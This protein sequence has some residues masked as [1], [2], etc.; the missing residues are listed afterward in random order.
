[1]AAGCW[2]TTH[3]AIDCA[4][5]GFAPRRAII[6]AATVEPLVASNVH[7]RKLEDSPPAL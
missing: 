7:H 1:M 2:R 3:F 5:F 4:L 6:T